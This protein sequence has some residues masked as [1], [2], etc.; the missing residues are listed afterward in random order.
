MKSFS[1]SYSSTIL[2]KA[3]LRNEHK[4]FWRWKFFAF[5]RN[6][7]HP[8]PWVGVFGFLLVQLILAPLS[9]EAR[10]KLKILLEKEWI[11][12]E[13]PPNS[14]I[15]G[16]VNADFFENRI[17]IPST[18]NVGGDTFLKFQYTGDYKFAEVWINGRSC[19]GERPDSILQAGP[20]VWIPAKAIF[21]DKPN[22][23]VVAVTA[24]PKNL[25][26]KARDFGFSLADFTDKVNIHFVPMGPSLVVKDSIRFSFGCQTLDGSLLDNLRLSYSLFSDTLSHFQPVLIRKEARVLKSSPKID[27]SFLNGTSDLPM[28]GFFTS[29]VCLTDEKSGDTLYEKRLIWYK[30]GDL[31]YS[32]YPALEPEN[33]EKFWKKAKSE[34]NRIDPHFS[35]IEL[36]K[37]NETHKSYQIRF[38][39]LGGD[40]IYA[41]YTIPLNVPEP[42]PG[43]MLLPG[44]TQ[45]MK[46]NFW[47]KDM[48]VLCVDVR[49]HGKSKNAH[50]PKVPGFFTSGLSSPETYIYRSAILDAYRGVDFLLSRPEINKKQIIVGGGSQGG[51]LALAVSGLRKDICLTLSVSPPFSNYREYFRRVAWPASEFWHWADSTKTPAFQMFRNLSYFDAIN[52]AKRISNPVYYYSGLQDP[53]TPTFPIRQAFETS[54]RN[55]AFHLVEK[56]G[57][58]IPMYKDPVADMRKYLSN[59]QKPLSRH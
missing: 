17:V 46:P 21:W 43:L 35:V 57:H 42:M 31:G 16:N 19:L 22:E 47:L 25:P 50:S 23:I 10:Q 39:S 55:S 18:L 49:A 2:P 45:A 11:R 54:N 12:T 41:W 32:V 58:N 40:T 30:E 29:L 5:S 36:P 28:G 1:V 48:A 56:L 27:V 52:F 34:L 38:L 26:I 6:F 13:V 37:E 20:H 53:I 4:R 33:W 24:T 51:Y 8:Y 44:Y 3:A 59:V 15:P 9:G 14:G 7:L